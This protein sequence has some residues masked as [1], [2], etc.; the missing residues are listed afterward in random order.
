MR[1]DEYYVLVSPTF[2]RVHVHHAD[3]YCMKRQCRPS[4]KYQL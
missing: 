4:T 2:I 3:F 1:Q